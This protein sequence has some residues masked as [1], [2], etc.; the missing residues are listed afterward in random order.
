MFDGFLSQKCLENNVNYHFDHILGRDSSCKGFQNGTHISVLHQSLYDWVILD[1][2]FF[3]LQ[4][5][6]KTNVGAIAEKKQILYALMHIIFSMLDFHKF[7]T[8]HHLQTFLIS[9]LMELILKI[10][11]FWSISPKRMIW[12]NV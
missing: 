12:V 4:H 11:D 8:V 6:I 5:H 1:W 3:G 9:S 2:N 10:T 7:D